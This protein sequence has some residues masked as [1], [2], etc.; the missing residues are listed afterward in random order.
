LRDAEKT[1]LSQERAAKA[2]R[3]KQ[4]ARAKLRPDQARRGARAEFKTEAE[5]LEASLSAEK[6]TL[7]QVQQAKSDALREKRGLGREATEARG[8]RQLSREERSIE[9]RAASERIDQKQKVAAAIER[10]VIGQNPQ[11]ASRYFKSVKKRLVSS[12]AMT[13]AEAVELE[14]ML[15]EQSSR[16][17]SAAKNRKFRKNIRNW[18][19]KGAAAGLGASGAYQVGKEFL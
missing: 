7:R 3:A 16:A 19:L 1:R 12:G 5:R 6:D 14:T 15:S 2:E 17:A 18:M 10:L 4:E 8:E 9:Q 13:E 11:T